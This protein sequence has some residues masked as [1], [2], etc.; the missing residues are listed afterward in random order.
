MARDLASLTEEMVTW[1]SGHIPDSERD[2]FNTAIK[3]Q[4]EL[5]E[6]LHALHTGDGDVG[7]ECADLLVLLLDVAY[8]NGVNLEQEFGVKMHIN[9]HRDWVKKSG[10]LKHEA[11]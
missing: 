1:I 5:S 11:D 7:A 6:L 10:A 4:E 3:M 9:R 2:S 8:L